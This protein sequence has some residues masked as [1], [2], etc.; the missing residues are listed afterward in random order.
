MRIGWD[1]VTLGDS[2]V[3]LHG[4]HS[5]SW[6]PSL[7]SRITFCKD[8]AAQQL[9]LTQLHE[10]YLDPPVRTLENGIFDPPY[11]KQVLAFSEVRTETPCISL[12]SPQRKV[13]FQEAMRSTSI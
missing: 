4:C 1:P 2:F 7:Y 10:T 11:K 6:V 12:W 13:V 8:F 9:H 3:T 5:G